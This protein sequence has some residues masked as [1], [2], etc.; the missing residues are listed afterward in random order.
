MPFN[1]I[2]C[3]FSTNTYL[4]VCSNSSNNHF[5]VE[6]VPFGCPCPDLGLDN[7]GQ[8]FYLLVSLN[9]HSIIY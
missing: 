5:A 3:H 4:L 8:P 6:F 1:A 7:L 2:Q 9:L